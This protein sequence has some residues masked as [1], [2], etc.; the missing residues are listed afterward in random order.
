MMKCLIILCLFVAA[1]LARECG[2]PK[3]SPSIKLNSFIVGGT[4]A[5]PHSY[6]WLVALESGGVQIC[7]ASIINERWVLTAAHC[8]VEFYDLKVKAGAHDLYSNK[9]QVIKVA[10]KIYH[11]NYPNSPFLIYDDVAL[12]KLQKP[13]KFNDNVQPICL[14]QSGLKHKDGQMFV[15]AGWG[16]LKAGGSASSVVRQVAVPKISDSVCGSEDYYGLAFNEGR[17]FCCGYAAGGKDSCQGDSGGPLVFKKNG[18]WI[19]GGI[20]S[21]GYGC[22]GKQKPGV[23]TYLPNYISWIKKHM[24]NN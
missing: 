2:K 14:P 20:V 9:V 12:L 19:Q 15:V 21:W 13:L 24:A 7:G 23:Y 18:K 17:E 4:V 8:V 11:E 10:K 22:A 3:V 16:N 6:P 1:S 5:K